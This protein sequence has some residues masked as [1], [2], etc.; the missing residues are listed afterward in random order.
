MFCLCRT[1]QFLHSSNM[2]CTRPTVFE[3]LRNLG[4]VSS[5]SQQDK[6]QDMSDQ[7]ITRSI[8]QFVMLTFVYFMFQK[9][10]FG[11]IFV[12]QV[13][14]FYFRAFIYFSANEN[15]NDFLSFFF[16]FFN[17]FLAFLFCTNMHGS[18]NTS[19]PFFRHLHLPTII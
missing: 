4:F 3:F 13:F 17:F 6:F 16:F 19:K 2:Y 1:E 8:L 5:L 18:I 10:S 11:G 9:S 7:I 12:S 15:A 14:E